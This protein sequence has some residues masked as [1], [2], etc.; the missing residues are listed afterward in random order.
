MPLVL[1]DLEGLTH[2]EAARRL[3][4]PVGTIKSRLSRARGRLRSRLT[5]RG[6]TPAELFG[7]GCML[8]VSRLPEALV[9]STVRLAS[10]SSRAR[11]G[12][13]PSPRPRPPWP[14]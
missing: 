13:P 9:D 3:G 2:E 4:V 8:S 7:A 11:R 6:L 12:S 10:T 14:R 5:R 1:C